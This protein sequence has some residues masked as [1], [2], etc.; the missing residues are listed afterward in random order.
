M[1]SPDLSTQDPARIMPSGGIVGDNLGQ[2]APEVVFAIATSEV[3]K[4]LIWAGTNDGKIWYTRDGG[5]EVERRL[6]ER[7]RH[8]GVGRRVEDRA[9]AFQRR[10]RVRRRRRAPDGQPR[11]VHLQDHRLRRD[12]EAGQ[13]RS[14]EHASAVVREGGGREPEQGTG[15]SS[16]A[17]ATASTTRPTTAATGP[18]WRPACRTRRSAGSWCRSSFTTSSISTYGR[19]L[20]VL[21]DITPLEQ[22][23]PA[24]TDAAAHLFT[25]RAGLPLV[26]ARPR[27]DQLL[28][29]GGAAR[30]RC[31]CR[32]ST[33]TARWSATCGST[34]RAGLNR[35]A[36]DLR[37]EPPR[38]IAMRT[39]PPE[40]PHIWE[41]PRFRGQDTRPVTHWGLEPA[42]VGPI[43]VPGKYTRE[44]DGRRPVVHAADRDPEGSEDRRRRSPTSICR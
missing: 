12:L 3:E 39:T 21:D 1:I 34:G 38:L 32:C 5:A 20:Y 33:P 35:V 17:P 25:P 31:S 18:S 19:G 30:R 26:A 23:T 8:A 2:F 41:E 36:W 14:A 24:T 15:C 11:A 29:E 16:P 43:V 42:Q 44:A 27:A 37:Y 7:H 4:G 13:R 10:H 28:A 40:N 22:A 6:E 9:V